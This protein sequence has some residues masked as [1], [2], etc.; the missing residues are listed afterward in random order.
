MFATYY[1][2][3]RCHCKWT[4]WY[5]NLH[6][7]VDEQLRRCET[8]CLFW[9]Q[10]L[11][12]QSSL[13]SSHK[14]NLL[15]FE[16]CLI[17][18]WFVLE[19]N[20]GF[21]GS[22]C[23]MLCPTNCVSCT[24]DTGSCTPDLCSPGYYGSACS[25][26]PEHCA[27][28]TCSMTDGSCSP[29]TAGYYGSRCSDVCSPHC[30]GASCHQD[31]GVCIG[32]CISGFYLPQCTNT[33]PDGCMGSCDRANAACDSCK[34]GLS[35]VTCHKQCPAN[36]KDSICAQFTGRCSGCSAG[37]YGDDCEYKCDGCL[38]GTCDQDS[39][40]CTHGCCLG[41]HGN[42]C[43]DT[44]LQCLYDRCDQLSG[45]CSEGCHPGFYGRKCEQLCPQCALG[46]CDQ[47][48]GS[49]LETCPPGYHGKFCLQGQS[50]YFDVSIVLSFKQ[51]DLR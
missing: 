47:W 22:S 18:H 5:N 31:S 37:F 12:L 15:H 38:S 45:E 50:Y 13:H 29:C 30:D 51:S 8:N 10:L 42:R 24:M 41:F 49:C 3:L 16:R 27:S 46:V 2:S 4:L 39:G 1:R 32:D 14:S 43:E 40:T 26:C 6:S 34:S 19:C 48:T 11:S 9:I 21:W 33:C 36:C 20:D 23:D 44:C 7:N 28:D 17:Y 25:P 35:G